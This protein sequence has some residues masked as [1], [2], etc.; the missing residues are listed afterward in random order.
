MISLLKTLHRFAEH[1]HATD[2]RGGVV[3]GAGYI[4]KKA[5]FGAFSVT[6]ARCC[7]CSTF[8]SSAE[9]THSDPRQF[10]KTVRKCQNIAS[11]CFCD[12]MSC[13]RLSELGQFAI[14]NPL[15]D[16]SLMG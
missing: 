5:M 3:G 2:R 15:K 14:E 9:K 13:V 7:S 16:F 4:N 12:S 1:R 11:A 6:R 8:H 10:E